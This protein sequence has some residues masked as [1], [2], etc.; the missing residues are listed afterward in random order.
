MHS[1]RISRTSVLLASLALL[2]TAFAQTGSQTLTIN[3]PI[4]LKDVPGAINSVGAQCFVGSAGGGDLNETNSI[5][6]GYKPLSIS[7]PTGS[8]T[9]AVDI[10][11]SLDKLGQVKRWTC[12]ALAYQGGTQYLIGTPQWNNLFKADSVVTTSGNF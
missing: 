4:Q 3:V 1:N 12:K 7:S 8:V 2:G 11:I 9:A 10:K 5:A 6:W